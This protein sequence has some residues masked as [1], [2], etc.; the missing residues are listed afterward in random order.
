MEQQEVLA[1][2]LPVQHHSP[3]WRSEATDMYEPQRAN[4]G[5]EFI[6]ASDM[7]SDPWSQAEDRMNEGIRKVHAG[8]AKNILDLADLKDLLRR[9]EQA[10]PRGK[11]Q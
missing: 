2:A 10:V 7:L 6:A 1:L 5:P 3:A 11:V 4:E 9:M 8:L